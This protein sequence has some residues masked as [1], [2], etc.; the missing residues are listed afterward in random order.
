MSHASGRTKVKHGEK[1]KKSRRTGERS[2][3]GACHLRTPCR[4]LLTLEQHLCRTRRLERR[5]RKS[6]PISRDSSRQKHR[7]RK[8][9]IR[10]RNGNVSRSPVRSLR[11]CL[12]IPARKATRHRRTSLRHAALIRPNIDART[13]RGTQ[14]PLQRSE[15]SYAAEA[16]QQRRVLRK[17]PSG[18]TIRGQGRQAIRNGKSASPL[19]GPRDRRLFPFP[20]TTRGIQSCTYNA[21]C[22][23]DGKPFSRLIFRGIPRGLSAVYTRTS[24]STSE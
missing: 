7:P 19:A 13:T 17:I 15:H 10:R 20:V 18:H 2:L 23:W 5:G 4:R 11:L 3:T 22:T 12:S 24:D 14:E 21:C 8:R 1:K 9:D 6:V 16:A